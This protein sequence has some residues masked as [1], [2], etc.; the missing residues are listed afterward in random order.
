M[1]NSI[2]E[3]T[4]TIRNTL[5]SPCNPSYHMLKLLT[6]GNEERSTHDGRPTASTSQGSRVEPLHSHCLKKKVFLCPEVEERGNIYW[7]SRKDRPNN[8][9]SGLRQASQGAIKNKAS[10]TGWLAAIKKIFTVARSTL[11]EPGKLMRDGPN[12]SLPVFS[13]RTLPNKVKVM[14]YKELVRVESVCVYMGT[15]AQDWT[16]EQWDEF[17]RD[18]ES[19]QIRNYDRSKVTNRF[20]VGEQIEWREWVTDADQGTLSIYQTGIIKKITAW[21]VVLEIDGQEQRLDKS[22]LENRAAD[23][24]LK[25][26]IKE[27]FGQSPSPKK[28][29]KDKTPHD[30]YRLRDPRDK[31]VFYVGISKNSQRR[32]KQHLACSGLN[33]K[34]NLRI[35]EILQGG[36]LPE[37]EIIEQ[38]IPG[39]E[40]AKER[41]KHW[42]NHHTQQGNLLTNIAEMDGCMNE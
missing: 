18:Y 10:S 42:I 14:L 28:S 35:Q 13:I 9:G 21:T 33:F 31:S 15:N 41:E 20:V 39:S 16:Q 19:R 25:K 5:T 23:F 1:N 12:K 22:F 36:L 17:I 11:R 27:T 32:Y 24:A 4:S 38:A 2:N 30:A 7:A 3:Y 40:K 34:L 29:T 6:Y 37:M 26:A 8:R